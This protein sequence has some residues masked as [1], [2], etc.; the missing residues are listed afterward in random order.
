MSLISINP[1]ILSGQNRSCANSVDPDETV[2]YGPSHQNL[3]CLPFCFWFKTESPI[4]ISG[5][6]QIQWLQSPLQKL[7]DEMVYYRVIRFTF[8]KW[9]FCCGFSSCSFVL[10]SLDCCSV[11]SVL[12]SFNTYC[13]PLVSPAGAD[14]EGVRM[15]VQSSL[16]WLKIH[17]HGKV[18]RNSLNLGHCIYPKYSH[19]LHFTLF[20]SSAWPFNYYRCE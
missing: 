1:I 17:F 6:V 15:G 11:N 9:H 18:W 4:C 10:L 14:L 8:K 2:R 5:L 7:G 19:A 16:L 13:M 12:V 20:F 3:H